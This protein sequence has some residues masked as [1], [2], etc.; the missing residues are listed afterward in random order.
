[1]AGK[2]TKTESTKKPFTPWEKQ[3]NMSDR[4]KRMERQGWEKARHQVKEKLGLV[5]PKDE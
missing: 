4:D 5:K 1:V 2:P 3:S